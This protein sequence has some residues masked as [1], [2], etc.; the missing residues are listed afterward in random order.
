MMVIV[1]H[2]LYSRRNVLKGLFVVGVATSI[3]PATV[4]VHASFLQGS[5]RNLLTNGSFEMNGFG[6]T[7][8]GWTVTE[9]PEVDP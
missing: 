3:S 4:G 9:L 2:T 7:M 6:R 8:T 1:S 5:E